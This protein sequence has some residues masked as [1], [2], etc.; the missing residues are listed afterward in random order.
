[1]N[2]KIKILKTLV[3]WITVFVLPTAYLFSDIIILPPDDGGVIIIPEPGE[4]PP[5][6]PPEEPDLEPPPPEPVP[7]YEIWVTMPD[8]GITNGNS[9]KGKKIKYKYDIIKLDVEAGE[10][11]S[12]YVSMAYKKNNMGTGAVDLTEKLQTLI[13]NSIS[14]ALLI[15]S[16]DFHTYTGEPTAVITYAGED[17]IINDKYSVEG[18]VQPRV[19]NAR[20][21]RTHIQAKI[22]ATGEYSPKDIDKNTK[23]L[24]SRE[25]KKPN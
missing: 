8:S 14:E 25:K 12:G 5:E 17:P 2:M 6:E 24:R 1:M 4:E 7:E 15:V 13:D 3:I 9:G 23:N 22:S 19:I 10:V 21:E 16:Y 20:S 11:S 18:T